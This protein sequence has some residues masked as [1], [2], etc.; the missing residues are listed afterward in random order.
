[1]RSSPRTR[2]AAMACAVP[3][4]LLGLTACG[5]GD[6]A[7]Y[8]AERAAQA[9]PAAD[10]WDEQTLVPAM[11]A[12]L[13]KQESVHVSLRTLG[14]S[15][16][17]M[18]AEG[19]VVL[20]GKRHPDLAVTLDRTPMGTSAEVRVVGD[21]LYLSMPPMTPEGKFL[22]VR[23]GD[24]SSPFG[25]MMAGP[26][27]GHSED[28]FVALESGLREVTYVGQDTVRGGQV[29]HY[30]LTVDPRAMTKDHH[31]PAGGR[32]PYFDGYG[33]DRSVP[34]NVSFDVW[35][36]SRALVQRVRF[37]TPR[38]GAVVVELSDWGRPVTVEAPPPSDIVRDNGGWSGM[39]G[40]SGS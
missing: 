12:A 34:R 37:E 21:V 17:P 27:G 5:T 33:A 32:M 31:G 9:T 14:D 11:R 4:L 25:P 35:L 26:V 8:T 29:A 3:A 39:P 16:M 40:Y 22:E 23:P 15:R 20:H 38:R 1:M 6:P 36:D 7:T 2:S 30:R 13:E 19:D 28:P 24:E 18:K 10:H